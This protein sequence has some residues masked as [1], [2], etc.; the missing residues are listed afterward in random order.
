MV[1]TGLVVLEEKNNQKSVFCRIFTISLV[2]PSFELNPR[3]RHMSSSV[4]I[5]PRGSGELFPI[6][7]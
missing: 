1:R 2:S 7:L 3:M 6:E 4:E 5:C